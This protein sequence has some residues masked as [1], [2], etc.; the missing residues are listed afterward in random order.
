MTDPFVVADNA[1]APDPM[2]TAAFPDEQDGLEE[3][4]KALFALRLCSFEH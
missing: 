1:D 3:L 2:A 4:V